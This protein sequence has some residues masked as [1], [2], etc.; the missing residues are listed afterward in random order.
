MIM[1]SGVHEGINIS[2]GDGNNPLPPKIKLFDQLVI[3]GAVLDAQVVEQAAAVAD[4]LEQAL[5]GA[6]IFAVGLEVRGEL[7]DAFGEEGDLNSGATGVGSVSLE[8][9][10]R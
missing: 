6:K 5:A 1:A 10:D 2:S 8:L 3:F 7:T 4:Q 9:F